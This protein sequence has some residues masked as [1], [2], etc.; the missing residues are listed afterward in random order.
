M[1]TTLLPGS[2]RL[3]VPACT[4]K[5]RRIGCLL[6]SQSS[7]GEDLC[8][9]REARAVPRSVVACGTTKARSRFC[10]CGRETLLPARI[11]KATCS[12]SSSKRSPSRKSLSGAAKRRSRFRTACLERFRPPSASALRI[13]RLIFSTSSGLLS[14][15]GRLSSNCGKATLLAFIRRIATACRRLSMLPWA[16][17]RT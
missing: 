17:R 1:R 8:R 12:L 2:C 13:D 11:R 10:F 9:G 6:C 15:E 7:A 16:T 14:R 5:Q 3:A 4:E